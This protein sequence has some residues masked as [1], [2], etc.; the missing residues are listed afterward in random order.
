MPAERPIE[1]FHISTF[2]CQMNLA[3]SS[4]LVATLKTRGYRRVEH[5]KDAD[6]II[7]NTCSVR[8]KAEERVIGRLGQ[9]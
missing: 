6:L 2:G 7:F 1:T 8:E 9:V 3:D 5:E 4:T